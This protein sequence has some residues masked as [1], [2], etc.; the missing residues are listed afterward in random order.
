MSADG[1]VP[2]LAAVAVR[3]VADPGQ[4][5]TVPHRAPLVRLRHRVEPRHERA[6]L[7]HRRPGPR[8]VEG[9]HAGPTDPAHRVPADAALP[10]ALAVNKMVPPDLRRRLQENHSRAFAH[11]FPPDDRRRRTRAGRGRFRTPITPL[12]GSLWRAG[13]HRG[14]RACGSGIG[15]RCG[16][17]FRGRSRRSRGACRAGRAGRRPPMTSR[18]RD[19]PRGGLAPRAGRCGAIPKARNREILSADRSR[20]ANS[21]R[22]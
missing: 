1:V 15:R 14:G 21:L 7:R 12:T 17:R 10:A 16:L 6:G 2:A 5:D 9:G 4:P 22:N 20:M 8:A 3:I 13:L 19:G 11:V 18:R